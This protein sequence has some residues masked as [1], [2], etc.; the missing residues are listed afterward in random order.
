MAI[1]KGE[2]TLD[3]K[4]VC[5]ATGFSKLRFATPQ[6]ILQKTGFPC[7]G[8]PSFGYEAIFLADERVL[9][10]KTV[11]SGGGSEHALVKISPQEMIKANDAKI[12]G[13]RK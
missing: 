10:R 5:A 4:K 1:L 6:E 9:E 2:D 13:I 3:V 8:T 7:G 12:I 11:F